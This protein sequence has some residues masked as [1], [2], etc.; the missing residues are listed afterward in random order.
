MANCKK[1]VT[2]EEKE[3]EI[4][5]N[6][7]DIAEKRKGRQTVSDPDVKK[8]ISMLEEFLKKK[9][10]VCYGGTA[11]NNILPLDDQFYDKNIEI[12]DYDFYSP[13]ALDDAKELA[14][15]YYNAGFHEVEAKAG[16]HHGTYKVYVNFIPVAD[17]TYLEKS[18]FKRVQ[19]EGIRVYGI[20]YCPP[21]FLRMN[22][23]LELSRPAGDISRWEKVLKRLILLNKNYP[24]KGKH[25]DPKLFQRQFEL[26]D[27]KKEEQL[28]YVVRDSFIDQ[29]LVFF[30]GYASFLY[31]EYMPA[32][33]RKLFQKTPDFDV[34]SEEPEQAAIMLKERLQDFDYTGIK[35][36]K[37]DGIGEL[38]AP[39]YEV[40]VKINNIDETIAFIYKPL[41][42]HS[43]NIIK[44]G[45]K[46][47]RVATIDT[48]LS[49]YFAFFYSG[50]EYYD[51]NR[52]LCMAQYLFDVQQ[53]NRL[54]QKGLLK[55]FSVNCY[56]EQETLEAMRNTKAKKYA[57]L[58]G[59]RNSK[60]YESWFL[61][62]IPFENKM[63]KEEKKADKE[64]GKDAGKETAK[65]EVK[66]ADKEA[67]AKP[68][69]MKKT[70]TWKKVKK[71]MAKTK[72]NKGKKGLFGFF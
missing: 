43:Y 2:L 5:R 22:M 59:Q 23:Y 38:V 53:K 61:R 51:E 7:I 60:E 4:L 6:A 56:G 46:T 47:V 17:I 34:L 39:H 72:K 15:I 55:R 50:R 10:L 54:E 69:K 27:V 28:Y 25:C 45:N 14:D 57:E 49:L 8:I 30:G 41:A 33:Q 31:S 63:D 9:R 3:V 67:E 65:E 19:K 1:E 12:P 64:A 42:C 66:E 26:V 35:I 18:L 36:V 11:I 44:R 62:Y 29:G 40:R 32:R 21:N 16:V 20:L 13:N 58:K 52:I 24:L 48:M 71:P 37:H 68:V 70:V